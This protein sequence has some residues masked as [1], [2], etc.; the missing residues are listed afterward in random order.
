VGK[1]VD[2]YNRL[3]KHICTAK[4]ST[5]CRKNAWIKGILN[6][7]FSPVLEVIDEC[8]E[9]NWIQTEQYWI[10]QLR[11]WNFN[12]L[13]ETEGG[14]GVILSGKNKRMIPIYE[15]TKDGKFME[16]FEGYLDLKNKYPTFERQGVQSCCLGY[17]KTYKGKIFLY[18]MC[19]EQRLPFLGRKAT[20]MSPRLTMK[21]AN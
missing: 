5:K 10:S 2:L 3:A 15:F 7:G 19:V 16:K 17:L 4:K 6:A 9:S 21:S 20:R 11:T 18:D 13:N 12:L 1:S 14:E 8:N